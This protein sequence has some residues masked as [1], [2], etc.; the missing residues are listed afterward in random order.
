M[1]FPLKRGFPFF[2]LKI[3]VSYKTKYAMLIGKNAIKLML[4]K[5]IIFIHFPNFNMYL[6]NVPYSHYEKN[7]KYN[8]FV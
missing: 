3:F 8:C 2:S 7:T 4:K 5:Q 6:K 1:I